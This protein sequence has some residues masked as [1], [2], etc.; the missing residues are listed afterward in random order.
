MPALVTARASV[1]HPAL[2]TTSRQSGSRWPA[3]WQ[4][5]RAPNLL[6][7]PGDPLAG[8]LLAGGAGWLAFVSVAFA[9]LGFY[10]FG[11]ITNDLADLRVD[12]RER[13]QR[14]L[15][16]GRIAPATAKGAAAVLALLALTQSAAAGPHALAVGVLLLLAVLLYNTRLKTVPVVGPLTMGACR[17]LNLLL[18]AA[19]CP[20]AWAGLPTP[21]LWLLLG[22]AGLLTLYI[23]GV[24]ALARREVQTGRAGL[25]GVLLRGLLPLQAALCLAAGAGWASWLAAGLLLALWP[26]TGWLSKRFYMS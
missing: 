9:S 12:R 11:L 19:A 2:M 7:V 14:P 6:T 23:A 24:T 25:I 5:L 16:S 17:G 20:V 18:G 15:P 8:W 26:I 21:R 4:L 22:A 13:P 3:W 1:Y 10:A